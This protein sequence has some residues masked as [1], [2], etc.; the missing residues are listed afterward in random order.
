M[1]IGGVFK[2]FKNTFQGLSTY[3]KKMEVI[4]ENIANAEKLPDDKGQVYHR[5]VV[6]FQG[7]KDRRIGFADELKLRLRTTNRKHI[8]SPNFLGQSLKGKDKSGIQVKEVQG[9]KLVYDPL[10][11]K[12]DEDGFVRMPNVDIIDEMVDM[13]STMRSYEA[14]VT[15]MDS[16]KEMAKRI[17][18]L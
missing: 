6:V 18:R 10:N 2:V 9:E 8:S 17:L 12:A 14:N 15:V 16:A 5:K 13:I 7:A 3:M 11:P 1:K 4:S